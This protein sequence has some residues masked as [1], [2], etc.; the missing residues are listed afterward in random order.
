VLEN[1]CLELSI[2]ERECDGL[3]LRLLEMGAKVA[4]A[5]PRP[6][7]KEASAELELSKS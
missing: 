4:I 7:G 1:H 2:P 6:E 5:E 3:V